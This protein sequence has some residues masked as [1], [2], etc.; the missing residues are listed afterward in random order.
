MYY[1][2]ALM[3]VSLF[4]QRVNRVAEKKRSRKE[5]SIYNGKPLNYFLPWFCGQTF[6]IQVILLSRCQL[7][8][9]VKGD[10][11]TFRCPYKS[12]RWGNF[13]L[14]TFNI[15][16]E[17]AYSWL[18]FISFYQ[19]LNLTDYLRIRCSSF[20]FHLYLTLIFWTRK[21]NIITSIS[22]TE[23]TFWN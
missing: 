22:F 7:N 5:R 4:D 20:L 10:H 18:N 3:Y 14:N 15:L 13:M 12:Y 19:N 6:E 11:W 9:I 16:N 17:I 2:Y 8:H 1:A 23:L 21:W